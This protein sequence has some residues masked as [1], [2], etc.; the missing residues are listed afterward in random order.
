MN[1]P[2]ELLLRA[3]RQRRPHIAP[4]AQPPAP[5]PVAPVAPVEPESAERHAAPQPAGHALYRELMRSHDRMGTR[6]VK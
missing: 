5:A 3:K 1:R 2:S 6:H 4:A